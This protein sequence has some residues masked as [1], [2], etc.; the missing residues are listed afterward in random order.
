MA[1]Y[2]GGM[3]QQQEARFA[4]GRIAEQQKKAFAA[5]G[6]RK[7][8]SAL[9]GMVGGALLGT[10]AVGLTGLTGGL[11]APLVMGVA[12]SLGKKWA[13]EATKGAA[14][15]WLKTPGQVGKIEAGG[16]YGY[17]VSA[18]TEATGALKASRKTEFSG[19]TMLGDI[20]SSYVTAGL[21]GELGGAKD[22][23]KGKAGF[24][25]ALTGT[26]DW[27][28]KMASGQIGGLGGVKSSM[29]DLLPGTGDSTKAVD[30]STIDLTES[31]EGS[32]LGR[33]QYDR[34]VETAQAGYTDV[35]DFWD[36]DTDIGQSYETDFAQ[37]G[38]VMDKNT[39]MGLALLSQMQQQNNQKTYDDTPLEVTSQPTIAEH[40]GSQ[41]KTL[42]G[43]STKSL[44][45]LMGR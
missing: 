45:Q 18:A 34:M 24:G 31:L 33:E 3:R 30:P 13:D 35:D 23:L 11:A 7:K 4:A 36:L 12:S 37:G 27:G 16:K 19:E 29:L 21:A 26:K 14:G 10:A 20:A 44:S 2:T 15:K 42:G 39:L 9:L 6:K 38:Q 17:G 22:L 41:N 28:A 25:E 5:E 8:R 1:I 40:F 43:S 32:G